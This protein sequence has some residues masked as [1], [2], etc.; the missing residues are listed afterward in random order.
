MASAGRDSRYPP[1]APR[2]DPTKPPCFKLAS[3]NSRN[4]CGIFCRLAISAIL[5][6]CPWGCVERSKTAWRAYSPLTE[7]FIEGRQAISRLQLEIIRKDGASQF[8][9][10]EEMRF[11]G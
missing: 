4:F 8:G 11:R 1:S 5:T 2:R 3:I 10:T 9:V 7:M 6:G